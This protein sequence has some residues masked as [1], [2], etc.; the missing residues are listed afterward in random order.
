AAARRDPNTFLLARTD[1]R[2]PEGLDEALRR[3]EMYLEAGAD[4]AYAEGLRSARELKRF[5]K[6]LA[7]APL[8]ISILEGGGKTPWLPPAELHA[9]GISMILYPTTVLFRA[10]RAVERAL[11]DLLAG[12]PTPEGEG[13]EFKQYEKLVGLP[14]WSDVEKRFLP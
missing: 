1:A 12:R 9:M 10:A 8:A 14:E 11:A 5:G 7:G 2:G 3:A 4:G 6:A 13:L